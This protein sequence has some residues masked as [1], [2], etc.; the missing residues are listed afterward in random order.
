MPTPNQ[1]DDA[2]I[3]LTPDTPTDESSGAID[4]ADTPGT[5]SPLDI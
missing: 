2:E 5:A 1:P 4:I 3:P